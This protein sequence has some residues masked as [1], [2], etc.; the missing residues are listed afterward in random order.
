MDARYWC[1]WLCELRRAL[2]RFAESQAAVPGED[3]WRRI[4]GFTPGISGDA[5]RDA[6]VPR[7]LELQTKAACGQ[8]DA[9]AVEAAVSLLEAAVDLEPEPSAQVESIEELDRQRVPDHQICLIYGFVDDRGRPELWKLGQE[10]ARPGT[11]TGGDWTPPLVARHRQWVAD[12]R[13]AIAQ[14]ACQLRSKL[15]RRPQAPESVEQLLR[16]GVSA[17]QVAAMTGRPVE[18]VLSE[19][20]RLQL[21][22][23]REYGVPVAARAP[24]EPDL[25]DWARAAAVLRRRGLLSPSEDDFSLDDWSQVREFGRLQAAGQSLRQIAEHL[26]ISYRAVRRLKDQ[27]EALDERQQ[28]PKSEE[29]GAEQQASQSGPPEE[30]A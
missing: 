15:P 13:Q 26:G 4:A 18:E 3:V 2:V 7:V 9:E 14:L 17:A 5:R 30:D 10:R 19:A 6:L 16:E 23:P 1:E 8:W 11:W 12:Q 28:R 29:Q 24:Q 20:E 25:D 22:V 21:A 27:W